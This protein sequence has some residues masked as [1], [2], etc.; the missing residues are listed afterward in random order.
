MTRGTLQCCRCGADGHDSYACQ[1]PPGA[2]Y[3]PE[4]V[5]AFHTDDA[6]DTWTADM[7]LMHEPDPCSPTSQSP[8]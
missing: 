7:M 1:Q 6:G 2:E 5:G 8:H 3:V 4:P